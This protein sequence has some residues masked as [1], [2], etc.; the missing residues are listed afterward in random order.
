MPLMAAAIGL[1][2][3][4]F[5]TYLRLRVSATGSITASVGQVLT[6]YGIAAVILQVIQLGFSIAALIFMISYSRA[7]KAQYEAALAI[8][9]ASQ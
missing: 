3:L 6:R 9:R 2:S 5:S 1:L 4:V 7:L 8:S